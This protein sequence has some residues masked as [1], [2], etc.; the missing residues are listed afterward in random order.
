MPF[1]DIDE[2]KAYGKR[3]Y[4]SAWCK[5]YRRKN[6]DRRLAYEQ[7]WRT[8]N[9]ERR[10]L[11]NARQRAR[12]YDLPCN[13]ELSDIVIPKYCPILGIKLG[14]VAG[15]K[16]QVHD[17]PSLDRIRPE[18]GYIKGNVAVISMRANVIKNCGTVEEHR[19]IADWMEGHS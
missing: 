5:E 18:L 19:K 11:S 3:Y 10:L 13:L 4:T 7:N 16:G 17:S 9:P 15:G 2:K 6:R 1:K 12:L 8:S 14:R